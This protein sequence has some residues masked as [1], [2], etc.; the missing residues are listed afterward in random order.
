[1]DISR[2]AVALFVF[3]I[4]WVL[5]GILWTIGVTVVLYGVLWWGIGHLGLGLLLAVAGSIWAYRINKGPNR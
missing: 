4:T 1:M 2:G 5:C 3:L